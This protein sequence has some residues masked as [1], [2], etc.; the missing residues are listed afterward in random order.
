MTNCLSYVSSGAWEPGGPG[1]PVPSLE[2][3]FYRVKFFKMDKIS[4]PLLFGPPLGK[5]RSQGPGYT[6][7]E[8]AFV[9]FSCFKVKVIWILNKTVK[10]VSGFFVLL[11][12]TTLTLKTLPICF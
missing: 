10:D 5:N 7:L 6:Y 3:G 1:G 11:L 4:F 8:N 9:G 2:F 12:Y